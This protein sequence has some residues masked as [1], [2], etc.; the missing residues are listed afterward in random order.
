[1]TCSTLLREVFGSR[2]LGG[3]IGYSVAN[4]SPPLRRF[5]KCVAFRYNDSEMNHADSLLAL[6]KYSVMTDLVKLDANVN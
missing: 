2:K 1:M 5:E 6:A 3:Q 4:G